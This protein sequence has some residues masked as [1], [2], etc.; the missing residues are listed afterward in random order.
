MKTFYV[1][2]LMS[3]RSIRK[4]HDIIGV[5]RAA[6]RARRYSGGPEVSKAVPSTKSQAFREGRIFWSK[7]KKKHVLIDEAQLSPALHSFSLTEGSRCVC[8]MSPSGSTSTTRRSCTSMS[9]RHIDGDD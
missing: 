3:S 1:E 4:D 9:S 8:W 2:K 6:S 7:R 5:G